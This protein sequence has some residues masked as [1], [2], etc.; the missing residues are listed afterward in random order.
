MDTRP[1][2]MEKSDRVSR[3]SL[4]PEF[5]KKEL[6]YVYNGYLIRVHFKGNKTLSQCIRNLAERGVRD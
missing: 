6:N 5:R 2:S 3:D 4:E 1:K